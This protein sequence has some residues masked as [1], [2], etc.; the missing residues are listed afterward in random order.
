MQRQPIPLRRISSQ[1]SLL[2]HH[3]SCV[4]VSLTPNTSISKSSERS[5]GQ[6]TSELGSGAPQCTYLP[7][8]TSLGRPWT[9][10]VL[11]VNF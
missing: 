10:P 8:S 6:L 7:S 9:P 4:S 1:K 3:V 2:P 5:R 11:S